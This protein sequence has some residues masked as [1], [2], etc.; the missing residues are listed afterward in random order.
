[1]SRICF[2]ISEG[3]GQWI[4]N[5]GAK[6]FQQFFECSFQQMVLGQLDIMQKNEGGHPISHHL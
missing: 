3:S 1:M 6:T 2:E 4:F 5:K